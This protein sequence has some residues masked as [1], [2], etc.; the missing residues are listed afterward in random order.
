MYY[1]EAAYLSGVQWWPN[2]FLWLEH[3]GHIFRD[4]PGLLTC[5]RIALALAIDREDNGLPISSFRREYLEW[6][7]A[8][9]E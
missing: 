7:L 5:E 6:R 4:V 8:R 9:G 3:T 1:P 2:D